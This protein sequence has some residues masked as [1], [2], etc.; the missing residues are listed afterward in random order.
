MLI[1]TIFVNVLIAFIEKWIFKG[2]YSTTL[3]V[4]S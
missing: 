4:L 2:S 1:L 3:E